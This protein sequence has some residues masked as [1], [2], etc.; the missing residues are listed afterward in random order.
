VSQDKR[1]LAYTAGIID[2]EGC[3]GILKCKESRNRT[4]YS[5]RLEIVVANTDKRL[6]NWLKTTYGG[7]LHALKQNKIKHKPFWQW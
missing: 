7:H 4:G 1:K 3:T 5:Y 2:G 6:V